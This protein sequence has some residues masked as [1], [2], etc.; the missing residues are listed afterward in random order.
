MLYVPSKR[1]FLFLQR[2]LCTEGLY[3]SEKSNKIVII[4][5]PFCAKYFCPLEQI[6]N[7]HSALVEVMEKLITAFSL[8]LFSLWAEICYLITFLLKIIQKLP[9]LLKGGGGG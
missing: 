5:V 4:V 1:N 6:M 9:I 2:L 3:E 7:S 8:L